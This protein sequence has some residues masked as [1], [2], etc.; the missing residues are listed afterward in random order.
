MQT[1]RNI[2][3]LIHELIQLALCLFTFILFNLLCHFHVIFM[4]RI[5]LSIFN[6]LLCFW[7]SYTC[8]CALVHYPSC[9][10]FSNA[11]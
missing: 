6:L 5:S 9:C 1:L 10:I 11:Y 7:I 3:K 4:V 8:P 2:F